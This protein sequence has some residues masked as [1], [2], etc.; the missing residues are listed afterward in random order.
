MALCAQKFLFIR[1]LRLHNLPAVRVLFRPQGR[2]RLW[3]H[4]LRRT[5]STIWSAARQVWV[6]GGRGQIWHSTFFTFSPGWKGQEIVTV[7]DMA[8]E[9]FPELF[10]D[11]MDRVGRE[12]KRRCVERAAAVICDSE[13]TRSDLERLI[14]ISHQPRHVVPLAHSE[15]F[16]VLHDNELDSQE[17][18]PEP[19]I[20][21]VGSRAHYKNFRSILDFFAF[22][23]RRHE[24]RLLVVGAP[25]TA[26]ER[27]AIR[28]RDLQTRIQHAGAISDERLCQLYNSASALVLPSLIEG[29]GL[30]LL[31]AMACGCPIAASKIPSTLEVAGDCPVYFE[32]LDVRSIATAINHLIGEGRDT[33]RT[34]AGLQRARLYSWDSTA[35]AYL[36]IFQQVLRG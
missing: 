8:P 9:R 24:I 19:F 26:H 10:N 25:W 12:A 29:F 21:Y 6:G 7:H 22:W 4:P 5:L 33:A 30:P 11:P 35:R 2:M 1:G 13:A 23:E 20:L 31:E 34:A 18:S 17:L 32:P 28:S 36:E 3:M 16:R 15:I 14:P 27:D